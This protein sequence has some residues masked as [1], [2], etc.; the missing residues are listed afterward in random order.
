MQSNTSV[1]TICKLNF[2]FK[3]KLERHFKSEDHI[4]F[5]QCIPDIEENDAIFAAMHSEEV[6]IHNHHTTKTGCYGNVN[7]YGCSR[8]KPATTATARM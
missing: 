1:R 5:A 8:G 7:A 2:P 3:S 6:P 4:L